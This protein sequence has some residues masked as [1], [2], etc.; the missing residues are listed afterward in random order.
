MSAEETGHVC[1]TDMAC[2]QDGRNP[3][4][5]LSHPHSFC[6]LSSSLLKERLVTFARWTSTAVTS[7]L[8]GLFVCP[9][10]TQ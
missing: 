8:H 5:E 2:P 10:S 9:G 7:K 1:V 4:V 6:E 3:N